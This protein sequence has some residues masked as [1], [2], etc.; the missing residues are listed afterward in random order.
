MAAEA[1]DLDALRAKIQETT[2]KVTE[3]EA[4]K[5]EVKDPRDSKIYAF[6]LDFRD[7]RGKHW[8]GRF[9][10]KILNVKEKMEAGILKAKLM[11]GAPIQSVDGFTDS[12]MEYVSHLTFSLITRPEWAKNILDIEDVEV[13]TSI[14]QEVSA[15]EARY[16]RYGEQPK[17]S[18]SGGETKQ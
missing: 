15:H 3:P 10:N 13:V 11:G 7:K 12:L 8:Q 5:E 18:E 4:A 17:S 16:F 2:P 14:Y 6:D 1:F 9:Q